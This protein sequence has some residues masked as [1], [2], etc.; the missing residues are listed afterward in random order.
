MI[1][2][3]E[4]IEELNRFRTY[5]N[6]VKAIH[7]FI[8][9]DS[10]ES[11]LSEVVQSVSFCAL[12]GGQCPDPSRVRQLLR[13]AWCAELQL[14]VAARQEDLLGYSNHWAPVQLYYSIY[15]AIRALLLACNQN[16]PHDHTATLRRTAEMIKRRP[17]L[18][19]QPWRTLCI[20]EP[21]E[22]TLIYPNLPT[23]V[24][25]GKISSLSNPD[26]A[27][28]WDFY[29]LLL[30][31]TRDK[32][33]TAAVEEWK[34]RAKKRR[35]PKD[36]RTTV[37]NAMA[38]TSFFHA[39][40]RLRLRSNYADAESFL[41]SLENKADNKEFH[42][43]LRSIAWYTLKLIELL[44]ARHVGK[45]QF[46]DWVEE[47]SKLDKSGIGAELIRRRWSSLQRLW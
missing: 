40:Y 12:R 27:S 37:I 22:P 26:F 14:S 41:I 4:Q 16:V 5:L 45:G 10:E 15:L 11:R 8:Q 39:L 31:T 19:P 18:F 43:S 3:D 1:L 28:F 30:R 13:N 42:R 47:F 6:Y 38:P 29:G 7:L 23:G 32:Q 24:V 34:K 46:G 17:L 2:A 33:S 36:T 21:G 25:I 9:K 35:I 20:G 44:L